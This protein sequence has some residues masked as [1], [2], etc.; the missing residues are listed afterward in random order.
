MKVLAIKLE[1]G[2][3]GL[4]LGIRG[5]TST[6]FENAIP[7]SYLQFHTQSHELHAAKSKVYSLKASLTV[8][9]R[10]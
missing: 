2:Q 4:G 10:S 6:R 9:V 5:G 7:P 3:N 1:K 8:A